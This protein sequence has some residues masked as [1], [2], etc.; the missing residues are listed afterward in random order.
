L[1][2]SMGSPAAFQPVHPPLSKRTSSRPQDRRIHLSLTLFSYKC[3]SEIC[4]NRKAGF[5]SELSAP[6]A[7]LTGVNE[8][9]AASPAV[10]PKAA[11]DTFRKERRSRFAR[12]RFFGIHPRRVKE[13]GA[14]TDP[15]YWAD[16]VSATVGGS[17]HAKRT[18][19]QSCPAIPRVR[20]TPSRGDSLGNAHTPRNNRAEQD[21]VGSL[22]FDPRIRPS[23]LYVLRKA[24]FSSRPGRQD[25]N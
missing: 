25:A 4:A 20:C 17:S 21:W 12:G 10:A 7:T 2:A 11:A 23:V 14:E 1:S 13:T 3:E 5:D 16:A 19:V 8:W 24:H 22:C 6:C 15:R 9:G 18:R